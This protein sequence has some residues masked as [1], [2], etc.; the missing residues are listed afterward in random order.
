MNVLILTN[1]MKLGGS[2]LVALQAASG[3]LKRNCNTRLIATK[4]L[5]NLNLEKEYLLENRVSYCDFPQLRIK[6][7]R[8]IIEK[9]KSLTKEVDKFSP[10]IIHS[11]GEVPDILSIFLKIK[12]KKR[13]CIK[14]LRTVHNERF[15]SLKYGF[16]VERVINI[17]F[18]RVVAIS[19]KT[20]NLNGT[21]RC[22]LIYNPIR[23]IANPVRPRLKQDLNNF[24]I[25]GRLTNQKG[26]LKFLQEI[27][28]VCGPSWQKKILLFGFEKSE[29]PMVAI[30]EYFR[31]NIEIRGFVTDMEKLYDE[32]DALIIPSEYEGLSTVMV[33]ALLRDKIVFSKNVSGVSDLKE[34]TENLVVFS[35]VKDFIHIAEKSKYRNTVFDRVQIN[36]MFDPN[37]HLDNLLRLYQGI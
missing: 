7:F 20:K 28:G 23:Q 25:I 26:Q 19:E 15:L 2:E 11:H 1:E 14:F 31:K 30:P 37:R 27:A 21:N 33:E 35:T 18:D 3:L 9:F 29:F 22:T 8:K 34:I 13:K 36:D 4:G 10:D 24:G 12:F 32:I 17:F 5:V 6:N 16:L